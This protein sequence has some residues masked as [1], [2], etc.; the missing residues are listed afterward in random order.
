MRRVHNKA[1]ENV[2]NSISA[3][4][5]PPNLSPIT[6]PSRIYILL[7]HQNEDLDASEALMQFSASAARTA[8]T[9]EGSSVT[10]KRN[11]ASVKGVKEIF[12]TSSQS[13]QKDKF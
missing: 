5:V 1:K 11:S 9:E 7:N 6:T 13:M 12:L 3:P 10:Q 8:I 2:P 4:A